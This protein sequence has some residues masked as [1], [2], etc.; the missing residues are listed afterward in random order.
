[1]AIYRHSLPQLS[2]RL[3]ITDGGLETT[4]IFHEKV[5]LPAFAAFTLLDHDS[6][7]EKLRQYHRRYLELAAEHGLGFILDSATWRANPDWAKQ[8]GY[9]DMRLAEIN[10]RAIE[11]LVRLRREYLGRVST[12][13]ISGAIGPRGDGYVAGSRMTEAEA[14]VYHEEQISVFAGTEADMVTAFT[15]NYAE[16]AIGIVRAGQRYR[17]PVA[18]SFTV[19]TDG[20]LPSGQT[21]QSAIEQVD[22]ATARGAAYF[23]I[24]CAHPTHFAEVLSRD[25]AWVRRI[26][27]VRANASRCSHAEL[28]E[29]T[30][31][32]D[33]NPTEFGEQVQE[34]RSKRPHLT[35]L[36]GCCGTDDRHIAAVCRS[37]ADLTLVC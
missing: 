8:L 36:G 30:E 17:I 25:A 18:I 10:C 9:S 29:S 20:K 37:C 12:M 3:F 27:G 4:L 31:L 7:R 19:E 11:E 32:D 15:L 22:A 1:M 33:G 5:D 6:G 35:I 21:L 24:N 13:V 16:E 26:R 23:M 14:Q 28:N 2:N 34:L